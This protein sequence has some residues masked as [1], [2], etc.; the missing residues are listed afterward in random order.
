LLIQ[1]VDAPAALLSGYAYDKFGITVLVAPFL[2]SFLPPLLTLFGADLSAIIA[3]SIVFGLILG[4]QESIY[5]AAVS[6]LTPL[7]SRGTAY[8][9]FNMSYGVGL[10]I[11]GAMYGMFMD[12]K[13]PFIVVV[14]Y[15]LVI[16]VA[17]TSSLLK[18]RS[19]LKNQS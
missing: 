18:A 14:F 15:V 1:G 9:I 3:A 19:R 11:S 7:S 4:M 8:G 13:L 5:R 16:Q 6:D 2:L 10:F 17:A 12:Y